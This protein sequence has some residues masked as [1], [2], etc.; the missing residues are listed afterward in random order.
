MPVKLLDDPAESS[1]NAFVRSQADGTF[2]HLCQWRHVIEAAF[3]HTSYYLL[4]EEDGQVMGIL[5]LMHVRSR[6]FSNALISTPFCVYGGILAANPV[7]WRALEQAAVELAEKLRVSYLEMRQREARHKGW[8]SK[9]LYCT[10]RKPIGPDS[11][12]NF[13]NVP[14]KQRAMIRKGMQAGLQSVVDT[15]VRRLYRVYSESVRNLGTP[16]FSCRYLELLQETFGS[17]CD[18]L[19]VLHNNKPVSSVMNFYFRDEVLPYYGGGTAAARDLKANDFMYW[20]VM[21]RAAEK[22]VGLFDFG[23]SKVD[24][25]PYHF[26]KHWGFD[27]KPLNYQYYLVQSDAMPD[28]SPVNPRYRRAI[29]T[30]QRMPVWLTQRLGPWFARSLG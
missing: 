3:N 10:F 19:T 14:R 5:P 8:P 29:A 20:E 16:V 23:R 22:G 25:G 26:K 12:A 1:W 17:A 4:Y 2:F 18:V 27:P 24:T 11:E 7:A 30:W 28:L 15:D 6:L 21:R 13:Q 9:N